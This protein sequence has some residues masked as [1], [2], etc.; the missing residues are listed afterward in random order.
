M[1]GASERAAELG[2]RPAISARHAVAVCVGVVIGAGIFRTPA[3]VAGGSASEAM[4]FAVWLIGGLLSIIGALCY[5]ELASTYPHAG[6]D[7]HFLERAYGRR[8]AFL[9]GW[10]RLTVIQTGSLA[11]LAYIFADYLS[12]AWP[13]GALGSTIYAAGLVVLLSWLNWLG[14]KQGTRAQLWMTGL[15]VV[16][17]GAVIS[18]GLLAEPATVPA[19]LQEREG[20]LGLILVFVLLTFGGWGE[21]VYLSAELRGSRRRIAGV[22]VGSLLAITSLYLAVN[23]AYVRVLGLDGVAASEA[24]AA[25]LMERTAGP[26][27][28]AAISLLVALAAL[29]SAN[30]TAIT[31]ARTT[32]A[33]GLTFRRLRWLAHWNHARNTPDNALLVQAAIALLLVLA[34]AFGRDEFSRIVEYTAPVFWFFMLLIGISQFILR[35]REPDIPR[36]FRTPL[37]P[38]IPAIFCLTSAYLLYS[39]LAYTGI[40]G[41]L[42]VAVL[43][44]GALLIPVLQPSNERS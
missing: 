44:F 33:L 9:Y 8:I 42:G 25:D 2:P 34:A 39:S 16:G 41:L 7:Y 18:A 19:V 1:T 15:Q 30:A 31:G 43:G 35:H 28:A 29:T 24:V 36:P 5:A 38:A 10:A 3:V 6:G 20:A 11:L 4:F 32:Y 12:A 22:L 23:W 17:L 27:G 21:V 14:V 40:S 13:L 37:Y 26:G